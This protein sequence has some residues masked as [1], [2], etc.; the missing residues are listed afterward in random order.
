[1]KPTLLNFWIILCFL[2]ILF[3][4]AHVCG[5]MHGSGHGGSGVL[6]VVA[7]FFVVAGVMLLG[8]ICMG[9]SGC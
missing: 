9:M 3:A 7:G 1:M 4:C 2:L 5:C 6:L 8:V